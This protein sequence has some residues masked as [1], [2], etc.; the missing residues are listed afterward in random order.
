MAIPALMD[1]GNVVQYGRTADLYRKPASLTS[2]AVFSDPPINK[3][4]VTKTG[5]QIKMGDATW[6]AQGDAMG[7]SDGNYIVAIRPHHVTPTP[8]DR[9]TVSL[10]GEVLVTELSGSESSAHFRL[11]VGDWVSLSHG[12]HPYEIG[13]EHPF[14]LDPSACFYFAP[15]GAVAAGATL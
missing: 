11:A 8:S 13:A 7:L 14:Y 4:A 9:H 10:T 1:D 3:A 12:V 6:T 2:A 5:D 15:D